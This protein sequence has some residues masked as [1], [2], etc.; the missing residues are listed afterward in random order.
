MI[1]E[2]ELYIGRWDTMRVFKGIVDK[3]WGVATENLLPIMPLIE[4]RMRMAG[5]VQGTLNVRIPEDYIVKADEKIN[6]EEYSLNKLSGAR[7][8]IKLQRCLILGRRA[9]IMR[10]DTHETAGW[11]H[12]TKCLE[13]MGREKFRDTLGLSNGSVVEIE[14]EGDEA[15]WESGK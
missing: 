2:S 3:G 7:E 13:V 5:L 8:T 4:G 12:G 15:W 14:V 1:L 11:G 10:P 6:P 9:I